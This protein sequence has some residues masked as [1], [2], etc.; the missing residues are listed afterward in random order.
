MRFLAY[1]KPGSQ[2]ERDIRKIIADLDAKPAP[3]ATSAPKK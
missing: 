3:K 2:A 1:T